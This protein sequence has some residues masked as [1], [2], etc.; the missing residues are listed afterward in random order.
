MIL[1]YTTN[2]DDDYYDYEEGN[3]PDGG[4]GGGDMMD[5]NVGDHNAYSKMMLGWISPIVMT[6]TDTITLSSFGSSGDAIFIFKDYN[7]S[8]FSEYY[9]SMV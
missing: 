4:I 9:V 8:F 6:D 5:Y 2:N 1:L 3:G 7:G